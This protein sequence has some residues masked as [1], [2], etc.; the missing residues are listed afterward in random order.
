LVRWSVHPHLDGSGV[1]AGGRS[2][3]EADNLAGD[4][5]LGGLGSATVPASNGPKRSPSTI[6][7]Y[8]SVMVEPSAIDRVRNSTP[9]ICWVDGS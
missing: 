7:A 8:S 1:A 4:L 5:D 2:D 9:A 6:T 3:F